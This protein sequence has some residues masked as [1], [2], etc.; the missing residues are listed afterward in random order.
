MYCTRTQNIA[1]KV[2]IVAIVPVALLVAN[3]LVFALGS[4][5]SG[6]GLEAEINCQ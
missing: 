2:T 3:V 6:G 5:A 1:L 4:K